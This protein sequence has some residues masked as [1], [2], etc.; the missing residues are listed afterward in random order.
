MSYQYLLEIDI[1]YHIK[2][3]GTTGTVGM[4]SHA[5]TEFDPANVYVDGTQ[6]GERTTYAACAGTQSTW[7]VSRGTTLYI[8]TPGNA[9]ANTSTVKVESTQHYSREG[10]VIP[11]ALGTGG[12]VFPLF[13]DGRMETVP[14]VAYSATPNSVGGGV[15]PSIGQIT[16]RNNDGHFDSLM[17]QA[18]WKNQPAR[19]YVGEE[20]GTLPSGYTLRQTFNID[21]PTIDEISM[22]IPT[23]AGLEKLRNTLND[24]SSITIL[25]GEQSTVKPSP[26]VFGPFVGVPAYFTGSSGTVG[27]Y[28]ICSHTIGTVNKVW[29]STGTPGTLLNSG[30]KFS[31]HPLATLGRDVVYVEGTGLTSGGAALMKAGE[32]MQYMLA[33]QAKIPAAQIDTAAF[34][35]LDTNRSVRM[36]AWFGRDETIAEALDSISRSVF[37]QWS[38]GRDGKFSVNLIQNTLGTSNTITNGDFEVGTPIIENNSPLDNL[39]GAI[40]PLRASASKMLLYNGVLLKDST[41][42]ISL[43]RGTTY[44]TLDGNWEQK[45][46]MTLVIPFDSVIGDPHAYCFYTGSPGNDTG[47]EVILGTQTNPILTTNKIVNGTKTLLGT[48]TSSAGTTAGTKT[49]TLHVSG[50]ISGTHTI[51][52][53]LND[54]GAGIYTT[55]D[56]LVG[57]GYI[58]VGWGSCVFALGVSKLQEW[59]SG[60]AGTTSLN[61]GYGTLVYSDWFNINGASYDGTIVNNKAFSGTEVLRVSR[62]TDGG[63]AAIAYGQIAVNAG[64]T[65]LL[66]MLAAKQSGDTGSFRLGFRDG[67]GTQYLSATSW[68]LGTSKWLR[69]NYVFQ[70]PTAG[71][72]PLEQGTI[73]IYPSYGGTTA[74]TCWID[75]VE[76]Y[77]IKTINSWQLKNF[78]TQLINP[79]AHQISVKYAGTGTV[80]R[81]PAEVMK[82]SINANDNYYTATA[83]GTIPA[84]LYPGLERRVIPALCYAYEDATTVADAALSYW[85]KSRIRWEAEYQDFQQASINLWDVLY[86]QD[87][88]FPGIPEQQRLLMVTE[89]EDSA[90]GGIPRTRIGGEFVFDAAQDLL[91]ITYE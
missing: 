3:W 76:M 11:K 61:E 87:G 5:F 83:A 58:A 32:I 68:G 28:Q 57:S 44:G 2:R 34:T 7:F 70:P 77:L 90:Q 79:M 80:T 82:S 39:S 47:Y 45:A 41:A 73:Q 72:S 49:L 10:A 18:L 14:S 12:T 66:T 64:S 89:I 24:G 31:A 9:D 48:G 88:R 21:A 91:S 25:A 38:V 22:T 13:Y 35:N 29:A 55:T 52:P 6:L 42:G 85:N 30:S 1:G 36:Q 65:Y 62:G 69:T 4:F 54:S 15:I 16:L 74:G 71:V 59:I 81:L 86:I 56:E 75:Y 63:S 26:M 8:H 37:S 67:S 40:Y 17:P 78:A 33:S 51:I 23:A 84:Y 50:N 19:L 60:T 46:T 20:G 53:Y 43:Y 27:T